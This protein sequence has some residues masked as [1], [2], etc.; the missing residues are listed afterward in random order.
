MNEQVN[1]FWAGA[2]IDVPAATGEENHCVLGKGIVT[3][4]DRSAL[5]RIAGMGSRVDSREQGGT[6]EE[7]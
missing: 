6:D 4:R 7:G 3:F 2:C 5:H 1:I